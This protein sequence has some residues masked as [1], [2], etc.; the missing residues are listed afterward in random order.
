MPTHKNPIIAGCLLGLLGFIVNWFKLPLFFDCD[1]L[2]GSAFAMYALLRYGF[3][4]GVIAAIIASTCTFIH[5]NHPW[6]IIIFTAEVIVSGFLLKHRKGDLL[7]YSLVYWCTFGG[8]F[9]WLF[10][11]QIMGFSNE[12]TG[13][14]FLKQGINGLFNTLLAVL[15]N[16]LL[17]LRTSNKELIPSLREI[18]FCTMAS[19]VMFP[20]L[21]YVVLNAR[22]EMT[23]QLE[24]LSSMTVRS[25]Q[26]TSDLTSRWIS[27]QR[28]TV[29]ALSRMSGV[30]PTNDLQQHTDQF[31][32][33][34]SEFNRLMVLDKEN[35]IIAR[36]IR[37][38][39][40]P[41]ALGTDLSDRSYI[42][43][44]RSADSSFIAELFQGSLGTPGPRLALM[45]QMISNGSY[46]G[47]AIGILD[48]DDLK[49]ILKDV[50]SKRDINLTLLDRSGR[51]ISS[52]HDGLSPLTK[53]E[54]L[55]GG[56]LQ[57]VNNEV[58]QWI[59]DS[60]PR[61][62][63]MKRWQRSYYRTEKVLPGNYGWSVIVESSLRPSLNLLNTE[64]VQALSILGLLTFI[65]LCIAHFIARKM[66]SALVQLSISTRELPE[67][68]SGAKELS[69]PDSSILEVRELAQ[70][71]SDTAA[72]LQVQKSKLA[73]LNDHLEDLV[74][75][76]T[77]E[78][79]TSKHLLKAVIDSVPACISHVGADLRYRLINSKYEK[80]FGH[81]LEL[82]QG[83]H[84]K[85][86]IGELGWKNSEPHITKVLNG[87]T[88]IYEYQMFPE[89][90]RTIWVEVSLVPFINP[91]GV[92]DGYV[93]H[94]TDITDRKSV[95]EE[96][97]TSK[98]AAEKANRSKSDF[99]ATMSH[100]IR[101]PMNGIIGMSQLLNMTELSAEQ[102]EYLDLI[103]TAGKSLLT[104]INDILDLAKIES[105]VI[106]LESGEFSLKQAIDDVI[107][108]LR[109]SIRKKQLSVEFT[110]SNEIADN[111]LGDQLRFKQIIVNLL[112]NAVK[113][114]ES[115]S[116][117]ISAKVISAHNDTQLIEIDVIDTGIGISSES[118]DKI[119]K[120]FVQDTLSSN[121][122]YGG[123]GLGLSISQQLAELM[124]GRIQVESQIGKGSTFS[125]L[126]PFEITTTT[127]RDK[128]SLPEMID[129]WSGK[130]L[131]I[132]LAEDNPIN[133]K[134]EI[135]LLK[136]L[137]HQVVS[138][139]DGQDCIEQLA[140]EKFD[141]VLMDIQMPHM[142][143][144]E[145]LRAIR[146]HEQY[147]SSYLPIIALT[148]YALRGEKERF[149][150]EGF[151]GY[152][153]KP[154][155]ISLLLGEIKRLTDHL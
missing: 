79:Q 30:L 28:Q 154:I 150:Q 83:R 147:K 119:F 139:T 82:M 93:A 116:V 53:Y 35:R 62:S 54:K 1:F 42:T 17:R 46:I 22:S 36:S 39:K 111:V 148:A 129:K 70:H 51:V 149:L 8:F 112:G 138:V 87:D 126:I 6:A 19:L 31:L 78:L 80:W 26:L 56:Y 33:A 137:G 110:M 43:T 124:G 32:E 127:S 5:W 143:G 151:D 109:P 66:T 49:E 98:D 153:S 122:N 73:K 155:D 11:H 94:I 60:H 37:E 44:L 74:L 14:I 55:T 47:A 12:T 75:M 57:K 40:V 120:P 106:D 34:N 81:P 105:G 86:M 131:R 134:F 45:K 130:S 64:T 16:L 90:G 104:L 25:A 146:D 2:F 136:K 99:L 20:A 3:T 59:P 132:L 115:G 97:V 27:E 68:V 65:T 38:D 101:T 88:D 114:T 92:R 103:D 141:L 41:I 71:F 96:L 21:F 23:H 69:L 89:N 102:H 13:V 123:T 48:I 61:I 67:V 108:I 107:K 72:E 18:V 84:V 63:K 15:I 152:V 85:E 100:E 24:I 4:A 140:T 135:A 9:V 121:H 7:S 58:T 133:I 52:T 29:L 77:K 95:T 125:L 144:I 118:L 50:V 113:F 117:T 142:D 10:Y 128:E 91:D 145:A 76:R